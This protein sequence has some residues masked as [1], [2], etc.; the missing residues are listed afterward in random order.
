LA[1]DKRT[2]IPLVWLGV[3]D[4]P[5]VMANQFGISHNPEG[6][7]FVLTIGQLSLPQLLGAEEEQRDQ[8]EAL[9]YIGI[10]VLGR[11]AMTAPRLEA[12][13]DMLQRHY[14][15]IPKEAKDAK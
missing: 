1:E 14:D 4:E 12:L 11:F 2:G 13:I 3:D 10:R 6:G 5:A 15:R 7:E 8:L 9:P